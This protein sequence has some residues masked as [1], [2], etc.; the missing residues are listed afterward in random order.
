MLIRSLGLP[1]LRRG[2]LHPYQFHHSQRHIG[3]NLRRIHLH[4]Q[5][6][7][8]RCSRSAVAPTNVPIYRFSSRAALPVIQPMVRETKIIRI[9]ADTMDPSIADIYWALFQ[10]RICRSSPPPPPRSEVV[11]KKPYFRFLVLQL[12]SPKM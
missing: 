1:I 12:L 4:P 9:L 3:M 6:G 10:R 5:Q 8:I 11:I 2:K 7:S